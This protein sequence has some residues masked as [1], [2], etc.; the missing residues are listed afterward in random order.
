MI[1]FIYQLYWSNFY[2]IIRFYTALYN[3][4]NNFYYITILTLYN[5][6][7]LYSALK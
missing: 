1:Y 2:K 6:A 7:R 4:E 5:Y 3:V